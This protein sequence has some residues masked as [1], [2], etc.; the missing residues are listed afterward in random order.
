M[1]DQI[2]TFAKRMSSK[3]AFFVVFGSFAC[4]PPN[5]WLMPRL[6][7][8]L[9]QPPK[10]LSNIDLALRKNFESK[11]CAFFQTRNAHLF[12][13]ALLPCLWWVKGHRVCLFVGVFSSDFF[14]FSGRYTCK[15][16][17][18]YFLAGFGW[19]F[20]NF[21]GLFVWTLSFCCLRWFLGMSA[22]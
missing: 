3:F 15:Y 9:K 19:S 12:L 2:L 4:E 21:G 5:D 16:L 11:F 14:A 13:F 22:W 6:K 18:W 8:T 17:I 20:S 1:Y 10:N 7:P